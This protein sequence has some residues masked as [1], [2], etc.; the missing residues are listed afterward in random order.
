MLNDASEMMAQDTIKE[1]IMA[2]PYWQM[3]TEIPP[4][5]RNMELIGTRDLALAKLSEAM[6]TLDENQTLTLYSVDADGFV[7]LEYKVT[8]K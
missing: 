4:G 5:A 8:R 2:K 1:T 7:R 6:K 3:T